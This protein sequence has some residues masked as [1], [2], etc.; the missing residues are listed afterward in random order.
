MAV[1]AMATSMFAA[2]VAARVIMDGSIG[3]AT[4]KTADG[5][6]ADSTGYVWKLNEKEQKDSDAAVFAV[7]GDKAGAQFQF[8]YKYD[9]SGSAALNVRSTNVWFKPVDMVKVTVGDVDVGT[10]KEMIDYWKVA[11][12]G[13]ASE[14]KTYSW[15]SYAT[16]SGPGVSVEVTPIDGLWLNA[17]LSAKLGKDAFDFSKNPLAYAAYGVAAKY[18]FANLIGAPLSAGVS[19]RDAGL[20]DVKIISIGCDY[21]NNYAPGLYAMLNVR[22]RM[23]AMEHSFVNT[24]GA[25]PVVETWKAFGLSA[26]AIDNYFKYS[27]GA[28]NV[29]L[30]APVTVRLVKDLVTSDGKKASDNNLADDP[31]WMSYELKATYGFGP[32]SAYLDIENDNAIT[33]NNKFAETALSMTVK[34]G[35][36]FNVGSCALDIGVQVG[37]PNKA[38]ADVTID[39]PFTA[40][41]SF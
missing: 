20:N 15:S 7:N 32:L 10:Y 3:G 14:H 24:T 31:A 4:I 36:T 40:S 17:G 11:D 30:R 35:V 37:V 12:G 18:S 2:D 28:L 34:P 16:V 25:T 19:L 23:E 26:V 13:R 22:L 29:Q 5:K 27:V 6:L 21:G 9:A 39:V 41:V 1:A 38:G 8:W 33:F